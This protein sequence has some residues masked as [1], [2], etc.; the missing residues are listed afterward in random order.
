MAASMSIR[1]R[2]F[3]HART[4]RRSPP[5]SPTRVHAGRTCPRLFSNS[6]GSTRGGDDLGLALRESSSI[7]SSKRG[8]VPLVG[9][10]GEEVVLSDALRSGAAQGRCQYADRVAPSNMTINIEAANMR[11]LRVSLLSHHASIKWAVEPSPRTARE[12]AKQG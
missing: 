11:S 10:P 2:R 9:S 4:S 7:S 8:F 1:L 3:D 6:P 12:A 5:I